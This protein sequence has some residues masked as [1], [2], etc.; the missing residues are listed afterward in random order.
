[1]SHAGAVQAQRR[2]EQGAVTQ[3]AW[4][5]A[6]FDLRQLRAGLQQFLAKQLAAST[7]KSYAGQVRL[8]EEFTAK[9]YGAP[10]LTGESVAF[11]IQRRAEHQH[12]LSSIETGL[13]ALGHVAQAQGLPA[14]RCHPLVAQA[15]KAAARVA[16][17]DLQQKLPLT[18]ELLGSIMLYTEGLRD[19]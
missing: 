19:E 13:A 2:R 12:R 3:S 11:W 7:A 16:P 8:Y 15:L 9:V 10:Q 4:E 18:V 5:E 14:P 1:M 17:A 6:A